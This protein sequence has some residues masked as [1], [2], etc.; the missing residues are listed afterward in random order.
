MK[1]EG[2]GSQ[3]GDRWWSLPTIGSDPGLLC[4]D[5]SNIDVLKGLDPRIHRN[6]FPI[7]NLNRYYRCHLYNDMA[8]GHMTRLV[9]VGMF[10]Y[11]GFA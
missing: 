10:I 9:F 3:M 11:H 5:I 8:V 2:S 6:S 4:L 1:L 7:N